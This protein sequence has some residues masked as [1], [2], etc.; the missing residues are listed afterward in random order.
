MA[1]DRKSVISIF[2]QSVII[3]VIAGILISIGLNGFFGGNPGHSE[4]TYLSA[5]IATGF[6]SAYFSVA[7]TIYPVIKKGK[8]NLELEDFK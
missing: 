6:A 7:M 3:G 8:V 2:I 5:Y 4:I 1:S